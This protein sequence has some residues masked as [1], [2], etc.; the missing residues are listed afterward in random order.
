MPTGA[1]LD[2]S[3]IVL[4]LFA[5]LLQ[6][7]VSQYPIRCSCRYFVAQG[8]TTSSTKPNR[9]A[10]EGGVRWSSP[11]PT[12]LEPL[13]FDPQTAGGLL[14]ALPAALL[15]HRPSPCI[16]K[17]LPVRQS[18]L[19]IPKN[20]SQM[21]VDFSVNPLAPIAPLRRSAFSTSSAFLPGAT[22]WVAPSSRW[23]L[24]F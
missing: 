11:P 17:D 24:R 10:Q 4:K 19:Q 20:D 5:F 18:P 15:C 21:L 16:S 2:H 23:V 6:F 8:V 9:E 14:I 12:D 13:A 3:A 1:F 22:S 7:T